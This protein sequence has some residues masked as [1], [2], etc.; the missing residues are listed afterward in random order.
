MKLSPSPPPPPR[1]QESSRKRRRS[2]SV[3]SSSLYSSSSSYSRGEPASREERN[4]RRRRSSVSPARRGRHRDYKPQFSRSRSN[5][6]EHSRIARQRQSI[7]PRGDDRHLKERTSN[8]RNEFRGRD[9]FTQPTKQRS[10]EYD[11]GGRRYRDKQ[12]YNRIPHQEENH[13]R[14][15]SYRTARER[16]P[17]P[18]C[19]Q[20]QRSLSPYS[21][22]LALTQAMNMGN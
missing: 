7:G 22:R 21:K 20:R 17:S 14:D 3:S 2:P 19:P 10:P 9:D 13:I 11:D 8:G 6:M 5:S 4:T 12:N 16:R 1:H 15:D 18:P